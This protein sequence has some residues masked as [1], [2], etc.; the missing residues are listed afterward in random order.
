MR[1]P[2]VV[3]IPTGDGATLAADLFR[4]R[5]PPPWPALVNLLP[6]RRDSVAGAAL[7]P[8]LRAFAAAGYACLLV[9]PRGMGSSD[10]PARPPFDPAEAD[11]GVAT[12]TWVARQPWCTGAVGAWGFSYGALYALR[13]ARAAPRALRAVVALMP[14][15][16]PELD[17]VH[18]GGAAGC[19]NAHAM[20]SLGTLTN[21]LLPPLDRH[22]DAAEQRRWR[23]RL[24]NLRPYGVDVL[25][26]PPGHPV[27]R[28]R[29][30]DIAAIDTP[31]YSVGGSRDMFA[32]AAVRL[33]EGVSGPRKLLLGPWSHSLPSDA[34]VHPVDL[35]ALTIRWWDRWLRGEPNGVDTEPPVT[36]YVHGGG[37][38]P[39]GDHAS[40]GARAATDGHIR[41]GEWID[42]DALP[43][44]VPGWPAPVRL[45][46][47]R[48]VVISDPTVGPRGGLW[49]IPHGSGEP[50]DQHGDDQRSVI[51]T[52]PRLAEPLL[53]LGRPEVTVTRPGRVVVKLAEVDPSGRS[54]L[55]SGGIGTG[56][57][58]R[59]DPTAY[60]VPA[61]HRLRIAISGGSFPRLW[62]APLPAGEVGPVTLRLPAAV[63]GKPATLPEAP[64][65]IGTG[66]W[67]WHEPLWEIQKRP[68]RGLTVRLGEAYAAD[69]PRGG[70]SLESHLVTTSTVHGGGSADVQ[71]EARTTA[72]LGT[73]ETVVVEVQVGLTP[74]SGRLQGRISIDNFVTF[75]QSWLG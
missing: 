66:L 5:T 20:W 65:R 18:P 2:V 17:F 63:S 70:V 9:D 8:L 60:Q 38:S 1:A 52:G 40:N 7:W 56:P 37:H 43:G 28:S 47:D 45:D 68:G 16:D 58:V 30:V 51:F 44:L 54:W 3:R 34:P 71:G 46:P 27:W 12:V 59:L 4:P 11:D 73:G 23:E 57:T 10:G 72:T 19:L 55:I 62:P 21:A 48:P 26:H 61:G 24:A 74:D 50:L 31:V 25:A 36:V 32:D 67:R 22:H 41:F 69:L 75:D 6:Y 39:T 35:A 14:L 49:G 29:V 53:V 42:L 15:L 64:P 13:T 33:Y